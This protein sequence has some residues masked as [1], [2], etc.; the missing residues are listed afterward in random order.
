MSAGDGRAGGRMRTSGNLIVASIRAGA[1]ALIVAVPLM[2]GCIH[3]PDDEMAASAQPRG[4]KAWEEMSR[5]EKKKLVQEAKEAFKK[6]AEHLE[7]IPPPRWFNIAGGHLD[8][9]QIFKAQWYDAPYPGHYR[10]LQLNSDGSA[11]TCRE[12][13]NWA[14]Q[15]SKFGKLSAQQLADIRRRIAALE[16]KPTPPATP[17]PGQR[18]MAIAFRKKAEV[19]RHDFIGPASADVQAIIDRVSREIHAQSGKRMEKWVKE[20]LEEAR[21]KEAEGK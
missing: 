5:D 2:C 16:L 4:A 14:S 7:S 6:V 20:L 8:D 18:H 21:K 13:P 9:E 17:E 15:N 3:H 10:V 1:A 11:G 12:V 19:I